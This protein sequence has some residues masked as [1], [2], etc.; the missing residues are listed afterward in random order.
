[1]KIGIVPILATVLLL[2][3]C[4]PAE[5]PSTPSPT[6]TAPPGG[7][8]SPPVAAGD[9][10]F[11]MEAEY[12]RG[13]PVE[14]TIRNYSDT[15]YYYQSYYPACYNLKFFDDSPERRAYPYAD[16]SSEERLLLPGQFIVPQGTHCD[17]I[18]EESLGPGQTVV[19][20]TWDQQMC[21]Q[22]RWGCIESL[23]VEPGKYRVR[24]EFSQAAGVVVPG[25]DQTEAAIT[26]VQWD[27]IIKPPETGTGPVTTPTLTP[28]ATG[29]GGPPSAAV[30]Q[31]VDA[32]NRF[33]FDLL[34]ELRQ[35]EGDQNLFVSP[36]S[37]AMA[38]AMTYN[39]AAGETQQAMAQAL[40][41]AEMD[42][43]AVNRGNTALL[44]AMAEREPDL[45]LGVA[46]SIWAREG[47]TFHQPFFDRVSQHYDAEVN[48]LPFDDAARERINSWVEEQTEGKIDSILDE[49]NPNDVM[50]L[51]NAI[52]FKA[53]WLYVFREEDTEEGTFHN[54]DG[55]E[56]ELP[57][58]RQS[59]AKYDYLDGDGFAALR[60]RYRG[61]A[62]MYLF[63]P[64]RDSSLPEFLNN[65]NGDAWA[66][67]MD[68]FQQGGGDIVIPRFEMEYDATLNEV[69]KAMGMEVAFGGGADFSDIGPGDLWIDRV[70]H[71]AVL[72]VH[73]KGT[74]A[75][76][77]TI[78]GM[79]LSG[80]AFTFEFI[81]DRPFFFAITDDQTG[82]VLFMGAVHQLE[83]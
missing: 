47:R 18:S 20:L 43:D 81:V 60:L 8:P 30:P 64:D 25:V 62:S 67:W 39:G 12:Q 71:K 61:N 48:S 79:A 44:A 54:A 83:G 7:E 49:I 52:Y 82:S 40:H 45:D 55:S 36:L 53:S 29:P 76:A 23:P 10:L 34:V 74:E 24:G 11:E 4:G 58:M 50:Y 73:E 33:A 13:E 38:L 77:A 46:N 21:I 28:T 26:A 17:L 2:V 70:M 32:N 6:A 3:A 5:D 37:V 68:G 35:Q 14:I 15:P 41:L 56:V 27:F 65:L 51:I 75:A 63:L 16:P 72:E 42:R 80:P 66:E 9:I 1:L 57:M 22:D 31:V 59:W 69:L 19:L 78:V